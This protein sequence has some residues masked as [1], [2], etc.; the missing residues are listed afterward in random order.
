MVGRGK[1]RARDEAVE[2]A[3]KA[4]GW[5]V[6][7]TRQDPSEAR[8]A[9]RA[10]SALQEQR[11]NFLSALVPKDPAVREIGLGRTLLGRGREEEGAGLWHS[12]ALSLCSLNAPPDKSM[13][14]CCILHSEMSF[15][16]RAPIN[17]Q[18]TPCS[19]WALWERRVGIYVATRLKGSTLSSSLLL[20]KIAK[21]VVHS[22]WGKSKPNQNTRDLTKLDSVTVFKKYFYTCISGY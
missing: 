4:S 3:R 11:N 18:L 2:Y 17:S 13:G 12:D 22:F 16:G 14:C 21:R 7:Q 5:E 6:S 9:R 20:A 8:Q 19:R 1:W 10:R 15:L